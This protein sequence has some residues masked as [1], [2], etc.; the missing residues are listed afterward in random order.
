MAVVS[1]KKST[2]KRFL[3][4]FLLIPVFSCNKDAITAHNGP[5]L[6]EIRTANGINESFE[7]SNGFLSKE[8]HYYNM[9]STPVD[10]YTYSYQAGKLDKLEITVR[11]LYSSTMTMCNPASGIRSAEQYE[12]DN[13]GRLNKVTRQSSY[14]IFEYDANG[15]A[16]KQTLYLPNG[17]L[18]KTATYK[19]DI[20]GNIVEEVDYQGNT[21]HYEYDNKLNPFYLLKQKPG[22][23]SVFNTSPNNVIKATGLTGGFERKILS[24]QA[25]LPRIVLDNGV[26]YTYVYH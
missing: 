22:W 3:Y 6:K 18:S 9:C 15:F 24:Y 4:I 13:Q 8:N 12:Y 14:T 17:T 16:I 19:Y 21:L 1:P 23:I 10:E 26:E 5:L 11:S 25:N 20:R 2:M 7:Y